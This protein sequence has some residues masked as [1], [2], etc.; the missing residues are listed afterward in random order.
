MTLRPETPA[1]DYRGVLTDWIL[2]GTLAVVS[3]VMAVRVHGY[4]G[5]VREREEDLVTVS[6]LARALA[7]APEARTAA[8]SAARDLTDAA[9]AM[10][11][12]PLAD[13]AFMVTAA[14]ATDTPRVRL[15]PD[16]EPSLVIRA[17]RE[18]RAV[19][20]TDVTTH[21][22]ANPRLVTLAGPARALRFEP[23]VQDDEVVGVLVVAWE[24]ARDA[25]ARRVR[26]LLP[27][28]AVE[29][30]V[31]IERADLVTRL[32]GLAL[33]DDLTTLGNRR[34]WDDWIGR[35]LNAAH[36]APAGEPAATLS[37][38]LLD[39]DLFKRFN[40]T[41]GHQ[42]GDRLLREAAIAWRGR[43]RPGD[44]LAR[45][46]G[47][48]FAVLLPGCDEVNAAI[49]IERL[50][51]AMP[52]GQTC[53]AGIAGWDGHEAAHELLGRADEALYAAKQAGRDQAATARR[54]VALV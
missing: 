52:H 3:A 1:T 24:D 33:T 32:A 20:V 41:H 23:I 36:A 53:S 37:V 7:T 4:A 54:P 44:R 47:E 25:T 19:V 17:A 18:R 8:C 49:V 46:G 14:D 51:S 16:R 11:W 12:E 21:P 50:R 30:A 38:A 42:E 35:A 2:P 9:W 39:I 15:V 10:L 48:E 34:A 13:G 5:T 29:A 31:S 26:R 43:L 27:L 6:R 28:L 40:D 22:D 45:Y